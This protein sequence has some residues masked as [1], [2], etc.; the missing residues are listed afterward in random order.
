MKTILVIE[1]ND[2]VRSSLVEVLTMLGFKVD[3]AVNGKEALALLEKISPPGL[4]FLDLMMPVMDGPT[5]YREMR[6]Q[7]KLSHVP[8]VIFSANA[9]IVKIEG[10]V[11]HLKKPAELDDILVFVDRYCQ[12]EVTA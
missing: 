11:G 10:A 5:F 6:N 12:N 8:V 1:D 2:D 7:T 3:E 4:I 9:D